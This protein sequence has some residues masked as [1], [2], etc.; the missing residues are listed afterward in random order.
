MLFCLLTLC[1]YFITDEDIEKTY[2]RLGDY[3]RAKNYKKIAYK[4][5]P[6]F[7]ADSN[8]THKV[9]FEKQI[10]KYFGSNISCIPATYSLENVLMTYKC[11]FYT[12]NSSVAIYAEAMGVKCYSYIPILREYT[13]AYHQVPLIEDFCIPIE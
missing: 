9:F 4:F 2:K 3:I 13:D 7:F 5:H 1:I 11:D 6:Y 8:L 12:D 10:N